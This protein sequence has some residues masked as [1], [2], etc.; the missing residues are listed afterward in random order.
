MR[1]IDKA[2]HT[3]NAVTQD[4]TGV[5]GAIRETSHSAENVLDASGK[6]AMRATSLKDG[7]DH[8]ESEVAAA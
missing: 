6:L 5:T 3:L 4:V 2:H 7:V 8:F 1:S